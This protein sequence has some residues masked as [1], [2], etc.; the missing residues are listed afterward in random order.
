MLLKYH[1]HLRIRNTGESRWVLPSW[2]SL[3][4][5]A[6]MGAARAQDAHRHCYAIKA[7]PKLPGWSVRSATRV[8]P[9]SNARLFRPALATFISS[10]TLLLAG[11]GFHWPSKGSSASN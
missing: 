11:L 2:V 4:V 1:L 7:G 9:K 10:L 6:M 3:Q 8:S 5:A